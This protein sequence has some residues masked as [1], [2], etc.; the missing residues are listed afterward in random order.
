MVERFLRKAMG[1]AAIAFGAIVVSHQ[2]VHGAEILAQTEIAAAPLAAMRMEVV[3]TCNKDGALFKVVNRGPKWPRT[4]NLK[5]YYAD[6]NSLIGQR[7][8]RL[9]GNQR[10]SFVVRK[11]VMSNRPVAVWVDPEWYNRSF[12][13]DAALEC[14]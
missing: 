3:G 4:G 1:G 5:L 8:L 13:F 10:V 9:A 11:N 12:R 6:D 2:P 7:R 14:P